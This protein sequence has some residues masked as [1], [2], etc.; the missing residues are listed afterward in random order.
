MYQGTHLTPKEV[1]KIPREEPKEKVDETKNG[2]DVVPVLPS[3][4]ID[5]SNKTLNIKDPGSSNFRTVKNQDFF[6]DQR[7]KGH[8]P[9]GGY[10]TI[11]GDGILGPGLE[12]FPKEAYGYEVPKPELSFE[13]RRRVVLRPKIAP[14]HYGSC[15]YEFDPSVVAENMI[16][17]TEVAQGYVKSHQKG[18]KATKRGA[19]GPDLSVNDATFGAQ[20]KEPSLYVDP[21]KEANTFKYGNQAHISHDNYGVPHGYLDGI[22]LVQLKNRNVVP[23]VNARANGSRAGGHKIAGRDRV[24][25]GKK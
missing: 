3:D 19:H 11:K 12:N 23:A 2:N 24:G 7:K 22:S 25:F 9:F 17:P 15:S 13:F 1:N 5:L 6:D 4:L 20:D 14:E 16:D 10:D 21:N 18:Y 8:G